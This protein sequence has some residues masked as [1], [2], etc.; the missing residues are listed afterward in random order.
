MQNRLGGAFKVKVPPLQFP[1]K[2]LTGFERGFDVEEGSWLEVRN[3]AHR[4]R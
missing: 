2:F 3:C 4:R 1:I